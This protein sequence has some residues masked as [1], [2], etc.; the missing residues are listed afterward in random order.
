M[1]KAIYMTINDAARETGL[2]SGYIR[3]RI[4]AGEII[5]INAGRKY[6]VNVPKLI[7]QLE[8]EGRAS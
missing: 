3:K 8:R 5:F 1:E 7:E 4:K 6:M 2:S